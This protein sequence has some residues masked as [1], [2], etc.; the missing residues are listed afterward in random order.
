MFFLKA[1]SGRE[2]CNWKWEADADYD[3]VLALIKIS[4]SVTKEQT[5]Q[6]KNSSSP[7]FSAVDPCTYIFNPTSFAA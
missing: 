6:N 3:V 1:A 4:T 5:L 7:M 2:L